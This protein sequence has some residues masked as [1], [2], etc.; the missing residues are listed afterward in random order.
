LRYAQLFGHASQRGAGTRYASPLSRRCQ[1]LPHEGYRLHLSTTTYRR[2]AIEYYNVKFSPLFIEAFL[3]LAT[4]E[5]RLG[6]LAA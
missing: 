4:S 5:F 3:I 6:M 1:F 2:H